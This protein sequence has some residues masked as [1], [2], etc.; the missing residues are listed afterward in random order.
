MWLVTWKGLLGACGKGKIIKVPMGFWLQLRKP[1]EQRYSVVEQWLYAVDGALQQ[2]ER[3]KKGLPESLS[4]AKP[5]H[6]PGSRT[7]V[8]DLQNPPGH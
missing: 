7:V 2:V 5:P 4:N 1:A 8:C 3:I 6:Y